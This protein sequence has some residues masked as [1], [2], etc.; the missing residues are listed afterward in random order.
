V[1]EGIVIYIFIIAIVQHGELN[2][3]LD[4]IL[5]IVGVIAVGG[6]FIFI[7]GNA[8]YE[9]IHAAVLKER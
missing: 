7:L 3:M 2:D 1:C 8:L 4:L 6:I 9:V 5:T